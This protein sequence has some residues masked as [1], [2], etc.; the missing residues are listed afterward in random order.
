[1]AATMIG[2]AFLS[3]TVQ[4]LVVLDDAEEKQI[5]NLTVKQ[6][7]DDLKNTI[8]DAEDL[9]N[10]ISYDSLRCKVE[11]TQVANKTN[12]VWNFLSSP[13][14][15]FY[16]EINSQMKIMCES[17][18]LFA[19]HKD[20]IG[21]ETKSARVSHRTPSSSGV[22]ESIM[23]GRKHDKD[24]LIDML[25]SD[26]TSRNNNLGVVATLGMGGV[27]KTTLAQLVYNDIKVEQHF[28]LKAWICVS[29]DFNVVRITK[30]LL[31]C[32]VRKTTYVDSNVWESD[33]LDILQVELMKHLMDRRF[34]F[35][36]DDIWNDNYIDWSE[37]ITPLTNR[38]TESKVIIT[39][40][41]QN[42]AEVAHTFPIHKLEPLSDEDCWSL[43]S[44]HAFDS[45]DRVQGN[46]QT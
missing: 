16:G 33:N 9:L 25:V 12:Q 38:G 20:I 13:F 27:G 14:K 45:E 18:Q 5:T 44:K 4:T 31:E 43:L 39:T 42:V 15:N 7:L 11:N 29:E 28:D 19:Q 32:V 3:A 10:Q 34:L 35:V 46:T 24:R 1:M 26:S 23:V 17:L 2:G 22:N 30:S 37:L 8:F 21:L 36:L 41:E 6:W 40:R